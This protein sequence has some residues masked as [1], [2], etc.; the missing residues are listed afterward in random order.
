[1]N[2]LRLARG[3]NAVLNRKTAVA[4]AALSVAAACSS[5]SSPAGSAE[6]QITTNPQAS[7]S[8]ATHFRHLGP[9]LTFDDLGGGSSVIQVYPCPK[10][11]KTD[12]QSNGT[13]ED[14]QTAQIIC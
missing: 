4:A 3:E 13:F 2:T 8:A 1:M 12:S 9:L 7:S 6:S 11:T 10:N 5:S 14:G